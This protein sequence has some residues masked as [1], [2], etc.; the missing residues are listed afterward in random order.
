MTPKLSTLLINIFL[1]LSGLLLIGFVLEYQFQSDIKEFETSWPAKHY[2]GIGWHFEPGKTVK[3]TNHSTY[4]Q[5]TKVNELGFLD[6]P[7]VMSRH[8]AEFCNIVFLGDSFVE[9]AQIPIEKKVHVVLEKMADKSSTLKRIR[10]S[11]FGYSGTGQVTQRPFFDKYIIPLRPDVLVM[12]VISN[13]LS[14][15]SPILT[16]LR[17]GWHPNFSPRP[18]YKRDESNQLEYNLDHPE[19]AANLLR[20]PKSSFIKSLAIWKKFGINVTTKHNIA[21]P[22]IQSRVKQII[23]LGLGNHITYGIEEIE[24]HLDIDHRFRNQPVDLEAIEITKHVLSYYRHISKKMGTKIVI[25]Y[26]YE[27]VGEKP[28]KT[29]ANQAIQRRQ[30]FSEIGKNLKIPIIFMD[31]EE[32][33]S[34]KEI[35]KV[36]LKNDGH[37]SIEGHG[38]VA[39]KL[40][41][42]L[43][44]NKNFCQH[45]KNEINGRRL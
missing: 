7:Q 43:L 41:S 6:R 5:E 26:N 8:S 45:K 22:I 33:I 16:S 32:F 1:T 10:T 36:L 2:K 31:N 39:K 21:D 27:I 14:D 12:V 44:R 11:A 35:G 42:F 15:N 9:A 37:W 38:E 24:T 13:D 28:N 17:N 29:I 3:W 23:N 30:I 20:E 25:L 19:W 40:F 18:F 34:Q 4:W